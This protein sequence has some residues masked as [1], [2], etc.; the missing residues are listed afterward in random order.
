M[1]LCWQPG[2]HRDCC[3]SGPCVQVAG[4][5][6]KPVLLFSAPGFLWAR[7]RKEGRQQCPLWTEH[8]PW[9]CI[10]GQC[11]K[12]PGNLVET[13]FVSSLFPSKIFWVEIFFFFKRGLWK[14]EFIFYKF[15][16]TIYSNGKT[17]LLILSNASECLQKFKTEVKNSKFIPKASFKKILLE[18]IGNY[19]GQTMMYC[20][21]PLLLF[22]INCAIMNIP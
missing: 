16:Q 15:Y 20:I 22:Y 4:V 10:K 7:E 14:S 12:V 6:A 11:C 19:A 1:S 8:V 17:D 13:S 21:I 9:N 5:R 18:C 2:G 3:S